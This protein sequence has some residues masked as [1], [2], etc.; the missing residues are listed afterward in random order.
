LRRLPDYG[1]DAPGV[2]RNLLATGALGLTLA[3]LVRY[4]AIPPDL[5]LGPVRFDLLGTGLGA[6]VALTLGG[7]WMIYSSRIG[8]LRRR[9]RLLNELAWTGGEQ[10]LDVGCGRGLMMIGAARRLQTGVSTGIDIWRSEDL[11]G[12]R[13]EATLANA[14]AEGVTDRVRVETADMRKLPFPD[15]TFDVVV[16]CFAIHNLDAAADRGAAIEEISRVLKPGGQALIDDIRHFGQYR[17]AFAAHG[18]PLVRRLDHPL[19]SVIW[20]IISWGSLRP[21]T[22]L[23]K[24]T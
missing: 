18:C 11:S 3:A 12:N 13:P 23:V 9:E 8:K 20:S 24:K 16:S 5:R 6:G 4:G 2:V 15:A 10:V 1:L 22:L 17:D 7:L 19:N 14:A 21:G